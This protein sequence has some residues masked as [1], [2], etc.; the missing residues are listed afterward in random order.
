MDD[1]HLTGDTVIVVPCYNESRRLDRRAFLEYVAGHQGVRFLFVDDGSTDSTAAVLE[2]LC[3]Q[4]PASLRMLRL[5]RNSGKAEAVRRGVLAAI[6][7]HPRY[8]AYWDADLSTPL[9]AVASFIA[10][11]DENPQLLAVLGSRVRRLGADVDRRPLRHYAGRI[12]ATLAS[13]ALGLSVYDTQ[14]GAK[15]FRAVDPV[16]GLFEK[17]FLSRWIFDVEVLARLQV[18]VAPQ[19]AAPRLSELPL[20]RWHDVA[21]SKLT[22]GTGIAAFGDLW[23]IYRCYR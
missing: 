13:L 2:E 12:F 9:D 4:A 5:E 17:P 1:H 20:R 14:C 19:S 8:V 16:P 18:A 7:G 21:G 23:R 3:G 22:M 10:A 15:M 11:L 6:T